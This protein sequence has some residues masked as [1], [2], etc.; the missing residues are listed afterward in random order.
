MHPPEQIFPCST[1]GRGL[2]GGAGGG[3]S[4]CGRGSGCLCT[5]VNLRRPRAVNLSHPR[6]GMKPED[7]GFKQYDCQIA[8]H[9][10]N[11]TQHLPFHVCSGRGDLQTLLKHFHTHR[12]ALCP[13]GPRAGELFASAEQKV[14]HSRGER[15]AV[16]LHAWKGLGEAF[17]SA[18]FRVASRGPRL[19][20][21]TRAA[22][23]SGVRAQS[24]RACSRLVLAHTGTSV[25]AHAPALTRLPPL[26]KAESYFLSPKVG[27]ECTA[28]RSRD[29]GYSG[30]LGQS[31]SL[32][33]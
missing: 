24:S 5:A 1:S 32:W 19:C 2:A 7:S 16:V 15:G 30:R 21:C 10:I 27:K 8:Q 3:S 26:V 9:A 14:N 23:R 13:P 20:T 29:V 33:G 4:I 28:S 11:H 6:A 31:V 12:D 18:G 25:C 17:A 22:P